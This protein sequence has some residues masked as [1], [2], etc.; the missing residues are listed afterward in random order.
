MIGVPECA[1]VAGVNLHCG[2]IAP[3][4][5]RALKGGK[6]ETGVGSLRTGAVDNRCLT[7]WQGSELVAAQTAGVVDFRM[8]RAAGNAEAHTN[9][10]C[11]VHRDAR[12][13]AVIRVGGIRALLVHNRARAWTADFIPAHARLRTG[14][15]GV[16]SYQRFVVSEVAVRKA[17]HQTV[18]ERVQLGGRAGLRDAG[19]TIRASFIKCCDGQIGRAREG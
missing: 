13:P 16:V 15:D 3:A 1:V 8:N 7:L 11:R 5:Q 14:V 2:V 10:A 12:H 9:V 19:S 4:R 18:A 6:T 17:V